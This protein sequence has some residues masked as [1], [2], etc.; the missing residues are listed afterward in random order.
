METCHH[1]SPQSQPRQSHNLTSLQRLDLARNRLTGKIPVEFLTVK[2]LNYLNV[3]HNQLTGAIPSTEPL[4]DMDP[5][6]FAAN[7][8]L[9][10]KPLPRKD[11]KALLAFKSADVDRSNLLNKW[12]QQSSCCAW[13]GVKCD[14]ASS[15]VSEL[16]LESMGLRGTLSPELGSLSQLQTL[17]VHD[18]GVEGPAFG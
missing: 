10:G 14:G 16:K 15:R 13:P 17:S 18:N 4:I 6:N 11:E 7:P 9:C 12:T 1:L 5:E 2:K 3:A 8:G